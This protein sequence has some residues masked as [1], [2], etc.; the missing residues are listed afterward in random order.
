MRVE[1]VA[2]PSDKVMFMDANYMGFEQYDGSFAARGR[3]RHKNRVNI[4]FV[5]G[6]CGA[7]AV[8]ELSIP[9]NLGTYA[10]P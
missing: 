8:G 7:H 9:V 1:R 3:F 6:H 5:D 2:R 10:D 4:V